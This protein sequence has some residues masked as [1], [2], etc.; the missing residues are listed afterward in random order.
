MTELGQAKQSRKGWKIAVV[1]GVCVLAAAG[2]VGAATVPTWA[3]N[4]VASETQKPANSEPSLAAPVI[5]PMV[6]GVTPTNG[7]LQV[8]PATPAVVKATNGTVK[9]VSLVEDASGVAVPGSL[10][11]DGSTWTA[12]E[13][14][15]FNSSY[16]YKFTVVDQVNRETSKTQTFT[17]VPT[18]HEADATSYTPDGS[19]VGVA[20][21]VQLT[22]SEPVTNKAAV[23]KA[24]KVSSTSGQVGAFRWYGDTMLRYRP[25]SFWKAGSTVTVDMKLFGVDF[26]NG[27]IGNFNKKITM[28]VGDKQV[29]EADAA[30][31]VA[32]YYVNDKLVK[33]IPVTMGDLR[34]PSAS[35]YLVV[36]R[37]K[38]DPA[39]FKASTIGL[40]PGDPA[41]YG[42]IT[43]RHATRLS[44]S[45]EFIHQATDSALPYIG[46]TNL[47]HGCIGMDAEN[48]K[49]MFD[50]FLFGSPVHV[51]NSTTKET[52]ANDDGFGDWNIPFAQYA[53]R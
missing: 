16:T 17:T 42:T 41:D 25:A 34:F 43:V 22:F 47:S 21:P 53:A 1:T 23:E 12:S 33:T 36:L 37:D 2:G 39:V 9:K 51:V 45:G 44:L 28:K 27:Q 31:H 40:K 48:A 24:I 50:N 14:L 26:G 6:L 18:T 38:Q 19:V 3:N 13:P 49:F 8:N 10:S 46:Q 11:A 30:A 29:L 7:A 32:K 4:T 5:K 35:G 52:I 20:Q 15:K